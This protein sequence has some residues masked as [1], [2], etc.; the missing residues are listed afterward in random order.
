MGVYK[1]VLTKR[2]LASMP[3]EDRKLFLVLGNVVNEVS[4]LQKLMAMRRR[5]VAPSKAVEIVENGQVTILMRVL[6]GKLHEAHRFF[7]SCVQ[8]DRALRER[9]RIAGD[10]EGKALLKQLNSKFGTLSLLTRMR[11]KLSFH[12]VDE[13]GLVE[14]SFQ[15]LPEDEE[16]SMYLGDVVANS[17]YQMSE[18][19]VMRAAIDMVDLE[20]VEGERIE[21]SKLPVLLDEVLE[22]AGIV[23]E[24]SQMLMVAVL[25]KADLDLEAEEIDVGPLVRLEEINL[26]F[27][28]ADGPAE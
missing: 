3:S 8:G 15:A 9:Y 6:V 21:A 2:Q 10:W 27:F 14:A 1:T 5:T 17:F 13:D 11:N 24:L 28:V 4:L 22:V 23:M 12:Y 16:W 19:V 26:P 25:D 7:Q 20:P 18:M